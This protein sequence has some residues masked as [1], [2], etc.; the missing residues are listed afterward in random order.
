MSRKVVELHREQEHPWSCVAAS[1]CI[2]RAWMGPD[3]TPDEATILASWPEPK[4]SLAN[5]QE[6]GR[7]SFW[8][9]DDPNSL[10]RLGAALRDRWLI[11]TLFPGPLTYFT[12][13]RRPA[14]VSRHGPLLPYEDPR[15]VPGLPHA[16]VLVEAIEPEGIRYLDPYYPSAGQPFSL[17]EDEFLEAW[18]GYVMIPTLPRDAVLDVLET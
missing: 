7:G 13:R 5:A 2:V 10:D 3:P 12:R 4:T 9:P 14:P 11:V 6:I 18:T 1:V 16:V 8:D 17:T 15:N